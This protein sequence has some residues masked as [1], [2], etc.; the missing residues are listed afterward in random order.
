MFYGIVL[1][2]DWISVFRWSVCLFKMLVQVIK[3]SLISDRFCSALIFSFSNLLCFFNIFC[4]IV[5]VDLFLGMCNWKEALK[6]D[7]PVFME[8]SNVFL[9]SVV[10]EFVF[11][12]VVSSTASLVSDRKQVPCFWDALLRVNWRQFLKKVV[13]SESQCWL[14]EISFES[15]LLE[16]SEMIF[17]IWFVNGFVYSPSVLKLQFCKE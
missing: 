11:F 8:K 6:L 1:A 16:L 10:F 3:L 2:F 13:Q 5:F 17:R 9:H 7:R 15:Q 4:I 14:R 12:R